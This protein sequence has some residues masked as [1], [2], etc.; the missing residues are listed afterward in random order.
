MC[1]GVERSNKST[2]NKKY[3][4][5]RNEVLKAGVIKNGEM[6]SLLSP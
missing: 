4:K 1:D 3:N 5:A 6:A 2:R